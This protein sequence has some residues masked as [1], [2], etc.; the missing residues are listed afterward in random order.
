M[1]GVIYLS[2]YGAINNTDTSGKRLF[3]VSNVTYTNK[4]IEHLIGLKPGDLTWKY[5][6]GE[7]SWNDFMKQYVLNIS[8]GQG[9]NDMEFIK[10]LSDNGE[11]PVLICCEKA[12]PCHR[13]ILGELLC[14]EG[15]EVRQLLNDSEVP[16]VAGSCFN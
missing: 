14:M 11:N 16:Y 12:H 7:I 1:K 15:Y 2:Y 3:S 13:F 4:P 8:N 9:R 10:Q 5:K 6:K